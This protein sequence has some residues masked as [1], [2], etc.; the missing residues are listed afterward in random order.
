MFRVGRTRDVRSGG[1]ARRSFTA[2]TGAGIFCRC[3]RGRS[4]TTRVADPHGSTGAASPRINSVTAAWVRR[5][6]GS[7]G[8]SPS[9]LSA[10]RS[11]RFP[12]GRFTTC[13]VGAQRFSCNLWHSTIRVRDSPAS[14]RVRDA[15][16]CARVTG[17]GHQDPQQQGTFGRYRCPTG[18]DSIESAPG[19]RRRSAD[20]SA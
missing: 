1:G 8:S 17:L 20:G 13:C 5:R 15:D 3:G 4:A 14:R 6:S 2:P 16:Y 19:G 18:S 9:S 10:Q 11:R 7:S 12:V